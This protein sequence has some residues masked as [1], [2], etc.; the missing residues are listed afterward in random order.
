MGWKRRGHRSTKAATAPPPI[1]PLPAQVGQDKD[2]LVPPAQVDQDVPPK[3]VLYLF[4]AHY[5]GSSFSYTLYKNN[6]QDDVS[7]TPHQPLFLSPILQLPGYDRFATGI[8]CALLDSK[9]YLLGGE[10]RT[11]H[12]YH[13]NPQHH[14]DVFPRHVYQF[15]IAT[16]GPFKK[17]DAPLNTGKPGCCVFAAAGKIYALGTKLCPNLS[18]GKPPNKDAFLSQIKLFEC[19]DPITNQWS[20]YANPC[21]LTMKR[22]LYFQEVESPDHVYFLPAHQAPVKLNLDIMDSKFDVP[23]RGDGLVE[24]SIT[25]NSTSK[26]Y[27][28]IFKSKPYVD[29]QKRLLRYLGDVISAMRTM[30]ISHDDNNIDGNSTTKSGGKLGHSFQA[31]I[32]HSHEYVMKSSSYN[33]A[34]LVGCF[35][36]SP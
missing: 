7:P 10:Y 35:V 34:K 24:M 22:A 17:M 20:R 26:P 5:P 18:F 28:H 36:V 12:A 13:H 14:W 2:T 27:L 16:N 31:K 4:F 1:P 6:L 29:C 11:D 32:L 15:D 33:L 9:F 30:E 3:S 8:R 19:F 25:D 21:P 23:S